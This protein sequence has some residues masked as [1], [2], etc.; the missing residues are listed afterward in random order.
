[1]ANFGGKLRT[2]VRTPMPKYEY[3]ITVEKIVPPLKGGQG[4]DG[5]AIILEVIGERERRE[6]QTLVGY[7]A[8][9]PEEARSK[10]RR[11][12]EKWIE[13]RSQSGG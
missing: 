1:M 8:D 7:W 11:A 5:Q 4:F 9:T 10:A 2:P 3:E 12:A 6:V 13:G